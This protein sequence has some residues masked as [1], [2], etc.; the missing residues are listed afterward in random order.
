[1]AGKTLQIVEHNTFN[2]LTIILADDNQT[3][4]TLEFWLNAFFQLEA[5]N[6]EASRREQ[7]RD[8]ELFRT[9]ML[10]TEDNE[11]RLYWT[12]RLSACFQEYLKQELTEQTRR[13]SDRTINRIMASLKPFAK[14]IDFITQKP[15][16]GFKPFLLGNPMRKVKA[17]SIGNRLEIERALTEQERRKMLNAADLLLVSAGRSKDRNRYKLRNLPKNKTARVFRDRAIIYLLT[18]SPIR[19]AAATKLNLAD[20]DFKKK[21]LVVE[22]KGGVLQTYMVS[23][24]ALVTINEYLQ[25]ERETDNLAWNSPALF[26]SCPNNPNAKGRLEPKAINFIWNKVRQIAD[27]DKTPHSTRHYM[28]R[29]IADKTKNPAAVQL[30]LGHRNASTSLQYMRVTL[31]E[32]EQVI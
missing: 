7:R 14:W 24:E 19:R 29:K 4:D 30:A 26:L 27:V 5:S 8:I 10:R 22:E 23:D 20:I 32:I 12:P 17:L 2:P 31:E 13:W 25:N 1:M 6:T 16:F 9:F 11:L 15:E 18:G 28:G 21:R 3:Q